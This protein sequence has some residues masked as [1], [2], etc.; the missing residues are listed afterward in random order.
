MAHVYFLC[1]VS[2]C[3]LSRHARLTWG[4]GGEGTEGQMVFADLCG[5]RG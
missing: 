5:G 4:G 2:N 3:G 1:N